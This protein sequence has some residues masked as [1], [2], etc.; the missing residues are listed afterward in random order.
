MSAATTHSGI[1][2]EIALAQSDRT[3][4]SIHRQAC[5]L[6][7]I[8][9][10]LIAAAP[11]LFCVLQAVLAEVRAHNLRQDKLGECIV[12]SAFDAADLI[13]RI[14]EGAK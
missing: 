1:E 10:R 12:A 9:A 13:A 2:R 11:D 3:A 5:E 7:R 14:Q 4:R 8:N 6:H